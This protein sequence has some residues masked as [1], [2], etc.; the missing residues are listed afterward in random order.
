M[1]MKERRPEVMKPVKI[2]PQMLA[3]MLGVYQLDQRI[4]RT[5]MIEQVMVPVQ[6]GVVIPAV[7]GEVLHEVAEV[8][9]VPVVI[10]VMTQD[11]PRRSTTGSGEQQAN[12]QRGNK[13]TH[14]GSS[15]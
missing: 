13:R 10:E 2:M 9:E 7:L 3:R 15:W 12:R 5:M 8:V 4:D 11:R 14:D 6:I 1:V